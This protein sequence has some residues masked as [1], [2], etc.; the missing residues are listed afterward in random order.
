VDLNWTAKQ[1]A[2]FK[3]IMETEMWGSGTG[4]SQPCTRPEA[5]RRYKRRLKDGVY[6]RPPAGSPL[7]ANAGPQLEFDLA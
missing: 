4:V 2:I 5:I 1:E 7:V 3:E 6:R